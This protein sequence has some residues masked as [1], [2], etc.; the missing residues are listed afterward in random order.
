[1][2]IKRILLSND[3]GYTAE[4]LNYI[5]SLLEE[6]NFEVVVVAPDKEMSATSHALTLHK[7]LR[8]YKRDKNV[9]SVEGTPTDCV[10]AAMKGLCDGKFD[11]VISGINHGPNMG[12]DV[13]YSGTV[14]AAYEGV[15]LG[16][17]S[18][19]ISLAKNER[20]DFSAVKRIIP[21]LI[22]LMDDFPLPPRTIY[23]INIPDCGE[24]NVKGVKLTKLGS[25]IYSDELIE[26]IDP[27]GKPYYWI[28]GSEPTWEEEE[29][30]D[31]SAVY[32]GYI[33]ITPL[34]LK[35]S[36][37]DLIKSY[38]KMEELL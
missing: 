31:F 18:I 24:K 17:P 35:F 6:N 19:A 2:G 36:D 34:H 11:L 3:D 26:K 5:K 7:P 15:M 4:G 20:T 29:G 12:E 33:S 21:S 27:R 16:V 23:N 37:E 38:K 9:Y 30:T 14:A 13:L 22:Y 25:R 10:L 1:M 32:S 28:G 8:I